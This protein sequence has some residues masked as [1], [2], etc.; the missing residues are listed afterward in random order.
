LFL[1]GILVFAGFCLAVNAQSGETPATV[2]APA[3]PAAPAPLAPGFHVANW[4]VEN[5]FDTVD[6][7]DNPYDDEFLPN[8]PTTRWTQVR[9]ETKLDNLA[10][11]ISGMN[12]GNGP[13]ILGIEEVEN[14]QVI[15]DLLGKLRGKS[16][17]IVHVDSPDPRGIDT[18]MLFNRDL[19]ALVEFHT[20][21]VRLPQ[22][23]ATRD[24]L[25]AILEDHDGRPLHVL[26]N[27][28]PSR[29]GGTA[30]S[31]PNRF[32]AART[33][34]RAIDRIFQRDPAAR[35]V[36]LGDFNDEP[37]SRSIRDVLDVKPYPSP[38]GYG[39]TNLYN[40]S[41]PKSAKGMGTIVHSYEGKTEWRMFDQIIVSGA[42]LQSASIE[43]DKDFF[44][45]DRP[46][47][48]QDQQGE[49]KGAPVPTFENRED[50]EGGYSDHFPVGARFLSR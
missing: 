13:D 12:R 41:A 44:R 4:N 23:Q 39:A 27:H 22:D 36:V 28:W 7:P 3:T 25:H 15:R 47:Y 19:F 24:I 10:R 8:N 43:Q 21:T 5:L 42:L 11:V 14:D 34:A 20:Y 33:L 16:Y 45:I 18:A 26:V 31:E 46:N 9:Y 35:V 50:Y 48:M 38:S 49:D 30:E 17:G 6:D 32:A 1:A 29:G 40:L 2:S 37:S